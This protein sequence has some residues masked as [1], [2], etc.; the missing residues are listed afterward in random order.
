MTF[1]LERG[2]KK[3]KKKK[4]KKI[5]GFGKGKTKK[6]PHQTRASRDK[7]SLSFSTTQMPVGKPDP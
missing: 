6:V 3:E 4:A 5:F 2:G 7:K 1:K